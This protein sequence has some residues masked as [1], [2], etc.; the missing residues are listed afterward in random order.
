MGSVSEPNCWHQNPM[1]GIRTQWLAMGPRDPSHHPIRG[2]WGH[3]THPSPQYGVGGATG[4]IPAPHKLQWGHGIP[5]R[6]QWMASEANGWHQNPMVG[7]GTTGL[8]PSPH[9]G[10]VGPWDP[11]QPPIWGS[12]GPRD[13][14]QHPISCFGV[15]GSI[16]EPSS[17]PQNPMVGNGTQWL[18][19]GPRDPSHHP[20][21]GLWGHG[22]H[23]STPYGGLWGHGTHPITP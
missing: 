19:M 1:V 18:A 7:N 8:I 10:A 21:R 14:S 4:P 16:S 11:S 6:T 5:L 22:T 12:V 23:P 17:W 2:L 20:I 9:K 3:G 15:M 13:P